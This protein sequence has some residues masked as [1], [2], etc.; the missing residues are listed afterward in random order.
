[1]RTIVCR[2]FIARAYPAQRSTPA[3]GRAEHGG[4]A[5]AGLEET[6]VGV[7]DDHRADVVPVEQIV[8]ACEATEPDRSPVP[9]FRDRQVGND[10]GGS[11][12]VVDVVGRH[13]A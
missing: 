7:I 11:H 3:Q 12:G 1:M 4:A 8:D 10:I 2:Y 13:A 5:S 6:A 9:G